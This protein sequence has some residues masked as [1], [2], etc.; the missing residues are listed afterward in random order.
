MTGNQA[1]VELG[2][3]L[4]QYLAAADETAQEL[5]GGG[6]P[7]VEALLSYDAYFRDGLWEYA[8]PTPTFG[9]VLFLHAYQLFLGA[10]RVALSG[11]SAAIF[12]LLRTA[13][14]AASYG[15]LLEQEPALSEV[16]SNRHRSEAEK[17]ACRNAF[18]FDKAIARLKDKA[19]TIYA[20][21]KEGYEGA[22]D[23]GAHPNLKGV[24]GHLTFDEDRSDGYTAVTQTS[25]YGA[26]HHKTASG[27]A[28]CLDFGFLVIGIIALSGPDATD[29]L[30]SQLAALNEIKESAVADV[31]S[32]A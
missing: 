29:N 27:L 19:P 13:L 7:L 24:F 17:K 18:T 8:P 26:N 14:E 4:R 12:P 31:Q 28:A 21:A 2:D 30:A 16:W 23:Y 1:R 20:M 6:N 25:L 10:V 5:L 32:A 3:G 9:F 15:F 11:H 22:I